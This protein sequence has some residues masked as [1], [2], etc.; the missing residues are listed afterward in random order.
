MMHKNR[1]RKARLYKRK[2]KENP[3]LGLM[4][5]IATLEQEN[6]NIVEYCNYITD[7]IEGVRE[8]VE[9]GKKGIFKL[10]NA[11]LIPEEMK[12]LELFNRLYKHNLLNKYLSEVIVDGEDI[13]SSKEETEIFERYLNLMKVAE[14]KIKIEA[15]IK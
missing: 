3:M 4:D 9:I 7:L 1:L 14:R 11:T 5:R 8:V 10:R 13:C 6:K 12:T 2:K 15:I